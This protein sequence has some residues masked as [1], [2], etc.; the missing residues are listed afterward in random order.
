MY[1]IFYIYINAIL[2][3]KLDNLPLYCTRIAIEILDYAVHS[4]YPT[5]ETNNTIREVSNYYYFSVCH[6]YYMYQY[7]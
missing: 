1:I 6:I 4:L 3:S 5:I 7:R 2:P